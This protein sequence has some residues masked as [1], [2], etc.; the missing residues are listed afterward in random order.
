M[1]YNVWLNSRVKRTY[2]VPISNIPAM[3]KSPSSLA[4]GSERVSFMVLLMTREKVVNHTI[5][6]SSIILN[7]FIICPQVNRTGS[8]VFLEC[9]RTSFKEQQ[10]EITEHQLSG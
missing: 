6:S 7:I 10:S 5:A 2:R 9:V 3:M 1:R 4:R 8:W